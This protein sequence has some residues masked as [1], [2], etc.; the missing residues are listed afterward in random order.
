[1][2]SEKML[3]NL[4]NQFSKYAASK[5]TAFSPF[6]SGMMNM[7]NALFALLLIMPLLMCGCF[8]DGVTI[9]ADLYV[10]YRK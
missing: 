8:E 1:M 6:Q 2:N 5:R 3:N 7:R 4:R 9:E 10:A